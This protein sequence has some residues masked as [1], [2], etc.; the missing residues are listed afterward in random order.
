MRAE[1]FTKSLYGLRE[2]GEVVCLVED[3]GAVAY[4]AVVGAAGVAGAAQVEGMGLP[5]LFAGQV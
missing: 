5:A 3:E 1:R 4:D 2:F